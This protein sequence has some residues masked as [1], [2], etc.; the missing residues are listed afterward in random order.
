MRT[1]R[2]IAAAAIAV[3]LLA[4][5][6]GGDDAELVDVGADLQGVDGLDA[7]RLRAGTDQRRR[8]WRSTRD[9]R[10]WVATAAF[11]DTGTDA[12]YVV[13][14]SG[15]VPVAVITDAHTPLGLLWVGDSL[16]VAATG[17]VDRVLGLRR[18]HLR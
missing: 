16:Y 13:D 1:K 12:V 11:D 6:C 3:V 2:W 18:H 15:A 5:G 8:R 14:E 10:L 4:A 17:G 9:G 7:S